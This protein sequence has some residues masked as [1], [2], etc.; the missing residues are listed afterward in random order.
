MNHRRRSSLLHTVDKIQRRLPLH[1]IDATRFIRVAHAIATVRHQHHLRPE[2]RADELASAIAVLAAL[3]TELVEHL[4]DR[5]AV[6]RIEIGIDFVKEVKGRGVALLNGKD[7]GECA[8]GFLASGELA[9]L[10]LLVV[11]GVEGDGDADAGVLGDF[12]AL[13]GLCFL[14]AV[15][16][17]RGSASHIAVGFAVDDEPALANG[18]ELLEYLIKGLC[19]LFECTGDGF[20]FTLIEHVNQVFNRLA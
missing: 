16:F 20:I 19:H 9:N 13:V 12:V 11:L 5:R 10:L 14:F 2:R 7:E 18:Y 3:S 17:V 15:V 6:L 4:R 1:H 8:E